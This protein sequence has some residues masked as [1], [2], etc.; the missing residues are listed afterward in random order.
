MKKSETCLNKKSVKNNIN[1][2]L[3]ILVAGFAILYFFATFF[4]FYDFEYND[5]YGNYSLFQELRYS[6][7][8]W[9]AW[10]TV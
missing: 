7:S 3:L 5:F 4:D 8:P 9:V 10:R 6:A 1:L 2:P